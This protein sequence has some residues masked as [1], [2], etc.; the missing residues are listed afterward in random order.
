MLNKTSFK[1]TLRNLFCFAL[2]FFLSFSSVSIHKASAVTDTSAGA[3][4]G[5]GNFGTNLAKFIEGIPG[6]ESEIM[7][8]VGKFALDVVG[9]AVATSI[10]Q[11]MATE[12]I[13]W[14]GSGF[15]GNPFAVENQQNHMY[16]I[17][18]D[19]I[20]R[21]YNEV[22]GNANF[23]GFTNAPA[24]KSLIG[25]VEDEIKPFTEKIQPTISEAEK[26]DFKN[27]FTKGGWDTYIKQADMQ[28]NNMGTRILTL[29]ELDKRV[30]S[31]QHTEEQ[32][33]LQGA[34]IQAATKCV[35]GFVSDADTGF[36]YCKQEVVSTAGKLVGDQI[37][38][39]IGSSMDQ[40]TQASASG[41]LGSIVS[42]MLSG[43]LT[44]LIYKGLGS[45]GNDSN[46][47]PVDPFAS[48]LAL[49]ESDPN[50]QTSSNSKYNARE[51][52]DINKELNTALDLTKRDIEENL[53]PAIETLSGPVLT[54]TMALDKCIPGPDLNFEDRLQRYFRVVL[55]KDG[56]EKDANEGDSELSSFYSKVNMA[57]GQYLGTANML[58]LQN[59]LISIAPRSDGPLQWVEQVKELGKHGTT[60]ANLQDMYNEKQKVLIRLQ[61]IKSSI[62]NQSGQLDVILF[63][64]EWSNIHINEN[65]E[66]IEMGLQDAEKESRFN[67]LLSSMLVSPETWETLP[68]E[69]KRRIAR[70]FNENALNWN[71]D[72]QQKSRRLA[73]YE[74]FN[75]PILNNDGTINT[76]EP[77]SI[78]KRDSVIADGWK[79]W[80]ES[81]N[82]SPTSQEERILIIR[83]LVESRNSY[84]TDRSYDINRAKLEATKSAEKQLAES[85]FSC[86]K[87][88]Y[89]VINANEVIPNKRVLVLPI[90]MPEAHQIQAQASTL[91]NSLPTI[92]RVRDIQTVDSTI[93]FQASYTKTSRVWVEFSNHN[94]LDELQNAAIN[95][96]I[97]QNIN[98]EKLSAGEV[99]I[100][101]SGNYNS[102]TYDSNTDSYLVGNQ[103]LSISTLISSSNTLYFK[104]CAQNNLGTVCTDQEQTQG[105]DITTST[106]APEPSITQTYG[107][108]GLSGYNYFRPS[109]INIPTP[110]GIDPITISPVATTVLEAEINLSN[111]N[112]KGIVITNGGANLERRL[113]RLKEDGGSCPP[114]WVNFLTAGISTIGCA[115][116]ASATNNNIPGIPILRSAKDQ[117]AVLSG[118]LKK[119]SAIE[120]PFY[121]PLEFIN[122]TI[123]EGN[124]ADHKPWAEPGN[125]AYVTPTN[126]QGIEANNYGPITNPVIVVRDH[127]NDHPGNGLAVMRDYVRNHGCDF[128]GFGSQQAGGTAGG[129]YYG[130]HCNGTDD[131]D[132]YQMWYP[133]K[134]FDYL[135]ALYPRLKQY[136]R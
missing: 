114:P 48:L 15:E 40:S 105:N 119:S 39:A 10:L 63:N 75:I 102:A 97:E 118:V 44:D 1:F 17:K 107:F 121:K 33:L 65:G 53:L 76:E 70:L 49:Q 52:V 2:V 18:S 91:F 117:W 71:L 84:T 37:G 61:S 9:K 96:S 19:E 3:G 110:P 132:N 67:T 21:L 90:D 60:L 127:H 86:Q 46:P 78:Q 35:E 41:D 4:S 89:E 43:L 36:E 56:L 66:E 22:S 64:D 77:T 79:K 122:T 103:D 72:S 115:A 130:P 68:T 51:I 11:T 73:L 131:V 38:K 59:S 129:K 101:I 111:G 106:V 29:T 27:N 58:M 98:N 94:N 14:A 5:W 80:E 83:N 126:P 82:Q 87:A 116:E 47:Q 7:Q 104:I 20:V 16:D 74:M 133:A 135:V 108:E 54:L 88:S 85:V 93:Y 50:F 42:S 123:S 69:E 128:K 6:T 32:K 26:L 24:F 136:V 100:P 109:S 125:A 134:S 45:I 34:G 13:N 30:A 31:R 95:R 28:N 57:F 25:V 92:Q 62:Q 112:V 8:Q 12:V 99:V 113:L 81:M 55:T 124:P 120:V 23:G